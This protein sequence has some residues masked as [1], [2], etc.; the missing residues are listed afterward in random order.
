MS[1]RSWANDR[2]DRAAV[3]DTI[4]QPG[5]ASVRVLDRWRAP[6]D[7]RPVCGEA[8]EAHEARVRVLRAAVDC[9]HPAPLLMRLTRKKATCDVVSVVRA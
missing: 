4:A 5:S 9:D 6:A 1:Y 8:V 2:L 7:P 3:G